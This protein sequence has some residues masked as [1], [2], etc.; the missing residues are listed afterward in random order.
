MPIVLSST[1]HA[2]VHV[3]A[4]VIISIVI[5]IIVIIIK[6]PIRI[7]GRRVRPVIVHVLPCSVF[8]RLPAPGLNRWFEFPLVAHLVLNL[9]CLTWALIDNGHDLLF[10]FLFLGEIE[11]DAG[12]IQM[13]ISHLLR[14]FICLLPVQLGSLQ[15]FIIQLII[16]AANPHLLKNMYKIRRLRHLLFSFQVESL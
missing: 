6:M 7:L 2:S 11:L 13:L 16:E 8:R 4:H 9:L 1:I 12:F 10:F 3:A 5:I 14:F 15:H